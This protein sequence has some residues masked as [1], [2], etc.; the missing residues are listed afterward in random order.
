MYQECTPQQAKEW[1]DAGDTLF[2]DMRDPHSYSESHI[3][4]AAKVNNATVGDIIENTEKDKKIVLYCYHGNSSIGGCSFFHEQGY[5][6]CYSLSGGFEEWARH[7]P[8]TTTSLQS[9]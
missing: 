6:N 2:W 4:G 1:Y 9:K 3:E 7:Y 5:K 8:E